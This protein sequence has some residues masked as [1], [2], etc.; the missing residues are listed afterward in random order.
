MF[1]Y[2]I[3]VDIIMKTLDVLF[4][5]LALNMKQHAQ[6]LPHSANIWIQ[7]K[8]LRLDMSAYVSIT[9]NKKKD[10]KRIF[11]K[12]LKFNSSFAVL[13]GSSRTNDYCRFEPLLYSEAGKLLSEKRKS[14]YYSM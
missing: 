7:C 1:V 3:I 12:L 10:A 5:Y 4:Y 9:I 8:V 13:T 14:K 11:P 2:N 6:Y